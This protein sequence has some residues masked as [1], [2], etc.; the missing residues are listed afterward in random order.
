MLVTIVCKYNIMYPLKDAALS[1]DSI[2][3]H[4]QRNLPA[5]TAVEEIR[6]RILQDLLTGEFDVATVKA[7]TASAWAIHELARTPHPG[8]RIRDPVTRK[9]HDDLMAAS[10][11]PY[12]SPYPRHPAEDYFEISFPWND[13]DVNAET[14]TAARQAFAKNL[15]PLT[16]FD[17]ECLMRILGSAELKQEDFAHYCKRN[18]YPLP[19]FWFQPGKKARVMNS[20]ETRAR[21]ALKELFDGPRISKSEAFEKVRSAVPHST[22]AMLEKYWHLAP[23]AWH[24]PGP[25]R[26]RS[27]RQR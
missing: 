22:A 8:V 14:F 13:A 19:P 26:G 10:E 18:R 20:V 24:K 11:F 16:A 4:W 17:D 15:P 5:G 2:A 21:D 23:K 25:I 27:R 6:H 12:P 3:I 1:L 7:S 9:T